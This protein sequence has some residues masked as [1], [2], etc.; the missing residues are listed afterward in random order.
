MPPHT[1]AA[2]TQETNGKDRMDEQMSQHTHSE[3]VA[4]RHR[5][6]L[7][8]DDAHAHQHSGRGIEKDIDHCAHVIA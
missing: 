6:A 3:I 2:C 8:V 5:T 7:Q 4:A 1:Q